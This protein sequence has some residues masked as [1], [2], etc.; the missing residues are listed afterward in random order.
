MDAMSR[1]AER[2]A[3]IAE[4]LRA[5]APVFERFTTE[6]A[7]K[8]EAKA[9]EGAE[10]W[11][12]EGYFLSRWRDQ[13]DGHLRRIGRLGASPKE[14]QNLVD[15]ANLCLLGHHHLVEYARMGEDDTL[16]EL[17]LRTAMESHVFPEEEA[18]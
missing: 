3:Q 2:A 14:I 6:M 17:A 10:G 16:T 5:L 7:D 18:E 12:D 4:R 1:K 9:R 13:L 8:L 15:V 11:D